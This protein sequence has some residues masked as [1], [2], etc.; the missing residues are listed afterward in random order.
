MT[1]QRSRQWIVIELDRLLVLRGGFFVESLYF[2]YFTQL[3]AG[4]VKVRIH[5]HG[6]AQLTDRLIIT[7]G[8]SEHRSDVR[9]DN[10][11]QWIELE[12]ALH[13]GDRFVEFSKR[14]QSAFGVPLMGR[15]VIW[16]QLDRALKFPP[17]FRKRKIIGEQRHAEGSVCFAQSRVELQRFHR[18][19]FGW[20]KGIV[21]TSLAV[22]AEQDIGVCQ[23]CICQRV[24]RV[25]FNCLVEEFDSLFKIRGSASVPKISPQEVKLICF[26]VL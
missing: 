11:R 12:R 19:S 10:D 7:S 23:T 22:S 14:D 25:L 17:R 5:L 20:R 6:L 26:G 9:I 2:Q 13:L 8:V 16:I 15:R 4:V 1:E 24:V 18:R 3:P 21:G